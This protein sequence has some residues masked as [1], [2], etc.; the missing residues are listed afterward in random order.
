M[1][2]NWENII[3]GPRDR[4]GK[5]GRGKE[6]PESVRPGRVRRPT[7]ENKRRKSN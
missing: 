4:K 5:V 7:N 6:I 2:S 3:K 1:M